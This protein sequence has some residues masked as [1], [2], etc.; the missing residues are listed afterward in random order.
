MLGER[1]TFDIDNSN[2]EAEK[3][4][5]NFSKGNTKFCLNL[6]YSGDESFLYVNKT[7]IYKFNGKGNNLKI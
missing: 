4:S 7:V 6:H 3:N 5:I 1:P 2:G